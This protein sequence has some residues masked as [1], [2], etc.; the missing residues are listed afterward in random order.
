MPRVLMFIFCVALPLLVGGVSGFLTVDEIS[1]WYATLQKPSFNPPDYLFG[2][3]WTALYCLMGIS[4]YLVLREKGANKK[5]ALLTFAL[6]LI[7]NFFWSLIFFNLHNVG[8]A[9]ADIIL[10]WF[11]ITDMIV[12]FYRIN[13]TAGLLQIPYLLWVTFATALNAAI[14][15]LN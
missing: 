3:V 12:T 11:C 1:G 9:L 14:L 8:L 5:H 7:L 13:K 4:L 10:L 2:P 6:Q 15:F